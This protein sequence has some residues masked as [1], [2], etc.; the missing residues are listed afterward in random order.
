MDATKRQEAQIIGCIENAL[1]RLD[2]STDDVE[3]ALEVPAD[4]QFG[5]YATNVAMLL[6]RVVKD[7]PRHLA[8]TIC[9]HMETDGTNIQRVE[10]AGP[11]FINFY[12][13]NSWLHQVLRDIITQG[14]AYGDSNIGSGQR[15]LL[16]FVS[17]NPTGPMNIVNAR[18]AAVG[19]CLASILSKAGYE[20][21]REYYVNDAGNQADRFAQS[22]EVR[23]RQILGEDIPFIE[24]GY[25][26]EYVTELAQRALDEHSELTELAETER[27]VWF[28]VHG[29]DYMVESQ[30][31]DL[32]EFGVK[33][34]CWFRERDLHAANKVIAVIAAMEERGLTY[35]ADDALWFRSTDFGDD[36]DRV[37]VR[38]DGTPTYLAADIA[39]HLD[40]LERGYTR[41]IDIWGPDHHGYIARTK[42]AIQAL[43]Y[44]DD[45]LEIIILQLVRLLRGGQQVRM[46]KRA[47][48]FVTMEE[49]LE[50][51]GK[52]A[53]RYFFIMRSPTSHLDFDLDLAKEQ[54]QNNPVYYIQ[55][56][57]ARIC[58][59]L[60][61]VTA[62]P[63]CSLALGED[64]LSSEYEVELLKKLSQYPMEV[65]MA[66][67]RREPH[68]IPRYAHEV[69]A[70]FHSFYSHCR[71]LGDSQQEARLLLVMAVKE[72]LAN[73]LKLMGISAPT[74]M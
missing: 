8:E 39:Y 5:D 27:T 28:K 41:L 10:V 20:V 18:A 60:K 50:E 65:E 37:L 22:L 69:A 73:T 53:A 57:H 71:V 70:L 2:I 45:T 31:H 13:K 4:K 23:F 67:L 44:G 25:P 30:R 36:K 74:S 32:A 35:R 34:D 59:L 6:A 58:S 63:D 26:G 38:A 7:K 51:V 15:V 72:V 19:D 21:A 64:E 66:A 11:G 14:S 33:F 17:A 12:L 29:L 16:E 46:S 55:Y 3:I 9:Q 49:L 42:A 68:R 56:A 47:G 52:D 24:D 61:E 54:S 43:G 48:E 62:L 1:E 40:K